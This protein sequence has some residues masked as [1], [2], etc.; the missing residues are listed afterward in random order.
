MPSLAAASQ[1]SPST[2]LYYHPH[3]SYHPRRFYLTQLALSTSPS[4]PLLSALLFRNSPSRLDA[5][6][7]ASNI[8]YFKTNFKTHSPKIFIHWFHPK[9]LYTITAYHNSCILCSRQN[10]HTLFITVHISA[11]SSTTKLTFLL[12]TIK[13]L[14]MDSKVLWTVQIYIVTLIAPFFVCTNFTL[15]MLLD[16]HI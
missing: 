12:S 7:K 5:F 1:I 3:L 9:I 16:L 6:Q 2:V 15:L 4:V 13:C 8:H 10:S 11:E 14:K